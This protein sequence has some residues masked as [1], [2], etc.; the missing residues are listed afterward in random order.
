MSDKYT[1]GD[2][3]ECPK[4]SY[5]HRES[6]EW[7]DAGDDDVDV[8]CEKCNAPLHISRDFHVSYSTTL[9]EEP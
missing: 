2:N 9:R 8:E 7:F 3:V 4:C 1:Y 5:V 6:C